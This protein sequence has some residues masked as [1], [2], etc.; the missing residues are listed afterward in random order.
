MKFK[1]ATR[2]WLFFLGISALGA[3]GALQVKPQSETELEPA[4]KTAS[5]NGPAA[6][7]K[8]E[9]DD[10]VVDQIL[11]RL[12]S[13]QI[14]DLRA[15]V[16]WESGD[17][18]NPAGTLRKMGE[19]WYRQEKP[20]AKFKVRFARKVVNKR[21]IDLNEE[22]LFNGETY[23]EL[24]E[25]TKSVISRVIRDP[26]DRRDPYKVGEGA[27]PLP[28][29]QRK[30]DILRE[31]EVTRLLPK[32]KDPKNTDHLK[33]IP[34]KGTV[35]AQRYKAVEFWINKPDSDSAGLPVKV[36]TIERS[37]AA[38]EQS[39]IDV[40][41]ENIQVNTGIG[42]A[43][44]QIDTPDGFQETYETREGQIIEKPAKKK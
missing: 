23:T 3:L 22:H 20:V 38:D 31:F 13:R 37:P 4:A 11:S 17:A 9:V 8:P 19:I 39:Y 16:V 32:D 14:D 18:V 34:R 15:K 10:E 27:F 44:F 36:R 6:A 21:A 24:N 29:G 28:F 41:F 5:D 1:R 40:L 33:L 43:I 26:G 7:S 2:G 30:E 42:G 25:E 12:E 35:S